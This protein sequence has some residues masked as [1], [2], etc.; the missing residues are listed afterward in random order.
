M[1]I[2]RREKREGKTKGGYKKGEGGLERDERGFTHT[3][4]SITISFVYT[5]TISEDRS[6]KR[7]KGQENREQTRERRLP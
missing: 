3:H 1:V 7:C 5:R 6:K 4:T 2:L